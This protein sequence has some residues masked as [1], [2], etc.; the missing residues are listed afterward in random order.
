MAFVT[1]TCAWSIWHV[2]HKHALEEVLEAARVQARVHRRDGG[3]I[4]QQGLEAVLKAFAHVVI[5]HTPRK[6]NIYQSQHKENPAEDFR[7]YS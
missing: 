1:Q 7:K 5:L 6:V 2:S 3:A 4:N